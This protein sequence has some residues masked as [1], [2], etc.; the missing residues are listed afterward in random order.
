MFVGTMQSLPLALLALLALLVPGAE[1]VRADS[2]STGYP[3]PAPRAQPEPGRLV[4]R[5]GGLAEGQAER[6]RRLV[7]LAWR[8]GGARRAGA[9][10]LAVGRR[11]RP[12]RSLAPACPCD[13]SQRSV[14]GPR[15]S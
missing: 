11:R 13:N 6:E 3:C 1:L 9:P 15:G 12:A 14:T 5:G 8:A 2:G 7:A 4:L 10:G